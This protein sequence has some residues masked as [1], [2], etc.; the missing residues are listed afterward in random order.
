MQETTLTKQFTVTQDLLANH[1]R[2]G[3]GTLPVL[4]TPSIVALFEKVS[5]ELAAAYLKGDETT[6]GS[7]VAVEHLAPTLPGETITVT[8][9][10][11]ERDGRV[12]HFALTAKDRAGVIAT[13]TH[14]RVSVWGERFMKKA[15]E[16]KN[17]VAQ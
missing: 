3:S 5:T 7:K 1:D 13:G 15:E 9:E 8:V 4:A 12:F 6:V 17:T 11:R 10:L 2:V 14:E 16:R